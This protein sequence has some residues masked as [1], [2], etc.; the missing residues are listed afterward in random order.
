MLLIYVHCLTALFSP[1]LSTSLLSMAF[2]KQI[3]PCLKPPWQ[4]PPHPHQLT[5]LQMF[6]DHIHS[7][8]L[9]DL[10]CSASL[11]GLSFLMVCHSKCVPCWA[12]VSLERSAR[13]S[14]TCHKHAGSYSAITFI[15]VC[16]S[17]EAKGIWQ[18]KNTQ[19]AV[20]LE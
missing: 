9:E 18:G 3:P 1:L 5:F 20:L 2:V 11:P 12:A 13:E 8:C 14:H 19:K 15:R 10:P 17:S 6:C 7:L 16:F 4:P